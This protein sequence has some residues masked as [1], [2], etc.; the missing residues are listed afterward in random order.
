MHGISNNLSYISRDGQ[1]DLEDQDGQI[2]TGKEA[3]RDLKQEWQ[4]GEFPIPQHSTKRDAFHLI[5]S[6]PTQTDPLSVQRALATLQNRSSPTISMRW[7]CT[8]SRPTRTP[9]RRV[10][11]MCISPSKLQDLMGPG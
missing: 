2:I 5:L 4:Q 6:M 9:T 1:L 3:V 8:R 10:I 7:C 11:R